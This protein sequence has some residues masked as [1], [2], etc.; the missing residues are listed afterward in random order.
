M[1][2]ST[3]AGGYS[4]E[5]VHP[6]SEDL[7]TECSICL[8]VLRN[9]HMVD[10]CCHRFCRHCISRV[11]K[12]PL[13]NSN[14]TSTLADKQL[15]RT[16]NQKRVYCP[17]KDKGCTWTGELSS[18]DQ[19][20]DVK[21]RLKSCQFLQLKCKYCTRSFYKSQ[22]E[23][24]ERNICALTPKLCPYCHDISG[25]RYQLD[26]HF[27]VCGQY[28]LECPSKCGR[29]IARAQVENHVDKEC[30]M[31]V[32]RCTFAFC[33][34]EV[35]KQRK[36]I[37]YHL[38]DAMLDH[39]SM[40]VSRYL[41]QKGENDRLLEE[42]QQLE[43]EVAELEHKVSKLER[44]SRTKDAELELL[45]EFRIVQDSTGHCNI[46][47]DENCVLIGNFPYLATEH[48]ARSLLG[49]FGHQASLVF[50][51]DKHMAVVKY[52]SIWSVERLL[53]KYKDEGIKL[54]G[55]LLVC[56]HL[57]LKRSSTEEIL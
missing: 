21:E 8:Q 16:L 35:K 37:S 22:I 44:E 14:F 6:V 52:D 12:C 28:P 3:D 10:C 57:K 2:R 56:A 39:L 45:K 43:E 11:N 27:K 26:D 54:R 30:Q 25:P 13:C 20:L 1:A 29:K 46:D 50:Y 41:I 5:F 7:Q 47:G 31:T 38:E 19:H 36:D 18:L 24:H 33:G 9:P 42:K 40:L 49:Q 48:M 53:G 55:N 51:P 17:D 23:E 4:C 32:K 15:E 34:C